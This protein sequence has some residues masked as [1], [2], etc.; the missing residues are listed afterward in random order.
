MSIAISLF[1]TWLAFRDT[2]LKWFISSIKSISPF[3]FTVFILTQFGMIIFRSERWY[4]L[5]K[6]VSEERRSRSRVYWTSFIGFAAI[7]V[8]PLRMGEIVR[9]M[10]LSSPKSSED[11]LRTTWLL[12]AVLVERIT[13]GII[14]SLT[15]FCCILL[16]RNP[17][18]WL[19]ITGLISLLFFIALAGLSLFIS[20]FPDFIIRLAALPLRL[21]RRTFSSLI[22]EKLKYIIDGIR[23]GLA[24]SVKRH[25]FSHFLFFTMVYWAFNAFGV[26]VL[27]KAFYLD[28]SLNIST[29]IMS[30]VVIGIFIPAAP[31]HVGNY[32]HFARLGLSIAITGAILEGPGMAFIF[33]LHAVQFL[34]YCF[35]GILGIAAGGL[36]RETS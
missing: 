32:H 7:L 29:L 36:N 12:S 9:P 6:G 27:A 24:M 35:A 8:L 30:L 10:L 19:F 14:M 2:D 21:T 16:I 33:T 13:D 28:V 34:L 1:F 22:I 15:V 23:K 17:P 31:G 4:H 5:V 25:E 11:R 3:W 20:F 26:F 18:N